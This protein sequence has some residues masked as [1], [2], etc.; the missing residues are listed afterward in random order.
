MLGV[1]NKKHVTK[2]NKSLHNSTFLQ[3]SWLNLNFDISSK[4]YP[5]QAGGGGV[6]C[7]HRAICS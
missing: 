2:Q 7:D 1:V 6:V 4:G 5:G 3:P